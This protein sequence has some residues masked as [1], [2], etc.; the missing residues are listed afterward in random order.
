MPQIIGLY[1]R[2]CMALLIGLYVRICMPLII[3]LY[4]TDLYG[5]NY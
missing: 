4:E 5:T 1:V 2:I 3:G